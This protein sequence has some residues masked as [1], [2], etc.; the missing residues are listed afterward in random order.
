MNAASCLMRLTIASRTSGRRASITRTTDSSERERLLEETELQKTIE[1]FLENPFWAEYY[2]AAP[3]G[4]KEIIALG[5]Y[6]SSSE[7]AHND[8]EAQSVL[9]ECRE[10][11]EKEDIAYL[12]QNSP[13][14][15][16]RAFYRK[17]L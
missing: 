17:I 13:N 7:M 12:A 16:E 2:D 9:E 1:S 5:F 8:P 6:M 15:Y 3:S 4:A 11:L 10:A 14:P